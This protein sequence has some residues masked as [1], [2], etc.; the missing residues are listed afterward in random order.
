M[1]GHSLI[2]IVRLIS[3]AILIRVVVAHSWVYCRFVLISR[4]VNK[5]IANYILF[6]WRFGLRFLFCW[7]RMSTLRS[8]NT[9]MFSHFTVLLWER[10]LA[11]LRWTICGRSRLQTYWRSFYWVSPLLCNL[12]RVQRV[13]LGR[14]LRRRNRKC[15]PNISK[16]VDLI[17]SR[18][19]AILVAL[20]A[21]FWL[22]FDEGDTF[23]RPIW[24]WNLVK[25]WFPYGFLWVGIDGFLFVTKFG[26]GIRRSFP[27]RPH[28]SFRLD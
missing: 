18:D 28:L 25:S 5:C 9:R 16:P 11:C 15:F 3:R 6:E 26:R 8:W 19:D 12:M 2:N 27:V 10:W 24:L 1:L 14:I 4:G 17:F 20:T 22:L 7:R 21:V 23:M 13:C